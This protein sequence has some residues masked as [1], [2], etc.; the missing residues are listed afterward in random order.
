MGKKRTLDLKES[1]KARLLM[2]SKERVEDMNIVLKQFSIERL[3]YR[4]SQSEHSQ[5]FVLKGAILFIVWE[6]LPHRPTRDVDFLGLGLNDINQ[7]KRIFKEICDTEVVDDGLFFDS[8]SISGSIIKKDDAYHGIRIKMTAYL[9]KARIPVQ[10]DI[11]YGDHVFPS[12]EIVNYPSLLGFPEPRLR[13]YSIYTVVS[14]KF[15]AIVELGIASTRMKDFYDLWY[16]SKSFN[17][18]EN[19]LVTAITET[20]NKRQTP[21]PQDESLKF[22]E[23]FYSNEQKLIQWNAFV[24]RNSL[25]DKSPPFNTIVSSIQNLLSPIIASINRSKDLI[26]V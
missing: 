5:K 23:E 13:A 14:E 17:I 11:G 22:L 24:K 15:H 6:S 1:V 20:F 9:G 7:V 25:L 10:A 18:E 21:I 12:P 8:D 3:L 16:L 4:L 19:I 26:S 2:L